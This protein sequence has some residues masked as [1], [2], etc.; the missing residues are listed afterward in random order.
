MKWTKISNKLN[1]FKASFKAGKS[2][3]G[4]VSNRDDPSEQYALIT[5]PRDVL[6]FD[7]KKGVALCV[8]ID[9]QYQR[10]YASQS[11]GVIV[12]KD[13]EAMGEAFV[14]KLGLSRDQVKVRVAS[15]EPNDCTKSGIH[16]LFVE[17]AKSVEKSS[18]FIFYFG[19]HGFLVKDRCVLAPADFGKE[20]LNGGI[21]GDDLVEWLYEAKCK[22]NQV[23]VIMDC[24][25]A[26][27]LGTTLTSPDNMLKIKPGLFVMCGCAAREQ[28][29]SIGALGHSIFT[30]FFLQYMETHHCHRGEF[31][32]KH[33]MQEITELCFNFSSLLF[34]YDH[35]KGTLK[36]HEMNPGLNRLDSQLDNETCI[37]ETDSG[38]RY[39][40]LFQFLE[41]CR[42]TAAPHPEVNNWLRAPAVK[43]SLQILYTKVS[44]SETLHEGILCSM[45]YSAAS[46]QS[47]YDKTCLEERNLFIVIALSVLRTINLVYPNVD[48][49]TSHLIKGLQHYSQP[50]LAGGGLDRRSLEKLL[51]EM[52]Q[53]DVASKNDLP[54]N[55]A[56]FHD[57]TANEDCDDE[58]DGP[59]GQ[60]PRM[61][62]KVTINAC[63]RLQS[64]IH[65]I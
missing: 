33:A 26:G 57:A 28:S 19:G 63:N 55:T 32:V 3:S 9:K 51:G 13:A 62:N 56:N 6:E 29:V 34:S 48:T 17:S 40:F 2:T 44:F 43:D 15:S 27:D 11:L 18:I 8:G 5:P 36:P 58:V 64:H 25:Y 50:I 31:A 47:G 24:C 7:Y 21:S 45:L 20:D 35:K 4:A 23:L 1:P 38:S 22:A 54:D 59:V 53:M 12:V 39:E 52:W 30:Y 42:L 37:D 10:R 60:S 49:T 16:A 46:I 61:M 65:I 41:E 14:D